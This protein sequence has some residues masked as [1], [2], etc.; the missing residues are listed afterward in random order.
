MTT[1]TNRRLF[2]QH[3]TV[4]AITLGAGCASNKSTSMKDPNSLFKIS[5]AEWSLHR[6]LKGGKISNLDFPRIAK[7][8]FGIDAIEFVNQFFMDKAKDQAYLRD[9]KNRCAA[10]GVRNVLIMCDGEG[11][12]G[13]PDEKARLKAVENHYKWVEAGKFLGCHSIRVNAASKGT[14]EEQIKLA[15]DGL[16]R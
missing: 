1:S 11:D 8:D 14:Y 6:A 16:R 4:A 2:L 5:L 10:E 15:A 3:C 7:K 9:L 13:N 12:L